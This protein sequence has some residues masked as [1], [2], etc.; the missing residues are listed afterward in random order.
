MKKRSARPS[1]RLVRG[2]SPLE[3]EFK[4]HMRAFN[5]GGYVQ[6]HRFHKA[7][8]WRLDFAW[9]D[10]WLA[11]EIEGGTH[12]KSRHTSFKGFHG[13]CDKYNAA[14]LQGWT[15]L[16]FDSAHVASGQAVI[17]VADYF[18]IPTSPNTG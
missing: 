9:L 16:R 7:R 5:V 10:D 14:A 6:E 2:D 12:G 1:L 17:I 11:V 15:V 3:A 4:R 18:G 8:Q 13:D